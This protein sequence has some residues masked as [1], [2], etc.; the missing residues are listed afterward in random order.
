MN[1]A[2]K[3]LSKAVAFIPGGATGL[4]RATASAIV[5]NGGKVA[6]MDTDI[7][8]GQYLAQDLGPSCQ[9]VVGSVT[10]RENIEVA[11]KKGFEAFN[12]RYNLCL[13]CASQSHALKLFN[14]KHGKANSFE[15][16]WKPFTVNTIGSFNVLATFVKELDSQDVTEENKDVVFINKTLLYEGHE[17]MTSYT[18]SKGAVKSMT[19][20][21]SRELAALGIRVCSI[22]TGYFDTDKVEEIWSDNMKM[23]F[24]QG[25]MHPKFRLPH[26]EEFV[27][28][29]AT[30]FENKMLNGYDMK[31]DNANSLIYS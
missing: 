28:A 23:N 7:E 24:I 2:V 17:L 3:S 16:F 25:R 18:S 19:V 1:S 6:V 22:S 20:P 26:S 4:G 12:L 21:A 10:E 15:Y 8:S 14:K 30:I 27:H 11:L 31:L 5:Q 9:F 29:V 13:N